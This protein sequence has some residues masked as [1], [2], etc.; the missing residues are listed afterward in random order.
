[1]PN[2][3]TS[4]WISRLA[5][6]S[7]GDAV[8]LYI[9]RTTIDLT[10]YDPTS[11]GLIANVAVDDEL[12][13]VRLNG[14]EL[15]LTASGCT[16]FAVLAI[17]GAFQVG[18]NTLDFVV[19]NTGASVNPSGL[20][21]E[22]SFATRPSPRSI[23]PWRGTLQARQAWQNT[24]QGRVGA[25][26]ALVSALEAAVDRTEE[27]SLV[28]L[29]D[30]LV[31]ACGIRQ[32]QWFFTGPSWLVQRLLI[33]VQ[34]DSRL[35]TT[36][37]SEATD[38]MQGL[39]FALR[40]DQFLHSSRTRALLPYA[41]NEPLT[42][43]DREWEWMGSY[44]K[45]QS[46]TRVFLY[47]ENLL[48]PSLRLDAALD[49]PRAAWEQTQAFK[50]FV[51]ALDQFGMITPDI[52]LVEMNKYWAALNALNSTT[53]PYPD[54]PFEL[55]PATTGQQPGPAGYQD[56]RNVDVL[57][58]AAYAENVMNRYI[59]SS[60]PHWMIGVAFL[61]EVWYCAPVHIALEFQKSGQFEAA[62]DWFRMVYAYDLPLTGD[63]G[64]GS[65][66]NRRIFWGLAFPIRI[67]C[68]R[69]PTGIEQSITA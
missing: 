69:S 61:W 62:L 5:D 14:A 37:L 55:T 2:T 27:L 6:E 46:M 68:R 28:S 58:L 66:V 23:P 47:P 22:F 51:S 8:G 19:N 34:E 49:Q 67:A 21:V 39:F 35:K 33:D 40:H 57:I 32:A 44:A 13:A 45:W 4:R 63:G 25:D 10:A 38:M 30:A 59:Y 9:Y 29:R 50:D 54:L 16:G 12:A 7:P 26:V 52:A 36:R 41:L 11:V 65:D 20:R 15:G 17:N 18:V 56:P 53:N 3:A 31:A 48:L 64:Q 42:S 24:L 60:D 43:F 1:M